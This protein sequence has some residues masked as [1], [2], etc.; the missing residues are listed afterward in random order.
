MY[1][2]GF[3]PNVGDKAIDNI[4]DGHAEDFCCLP[5]WQRK[6]AQTKKKKLFGDFYIGNKVN[7]YLQH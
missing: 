1:H 7:A 5:C 3:T 6:I 4:A 2:D